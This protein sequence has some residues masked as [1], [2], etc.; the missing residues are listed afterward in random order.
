[1]I[2]H[3]N[4]MTGK[5][6]PRIVRGVVLSEAG[7]PVKDVVVSLTA[8]P[9]PLQDIAALTGAGGDFVLTAPAPGEYVVMASYP[10]GQQE[11]RTVAVAEDAIEVTLE[12]RPN[13]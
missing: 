3:G 10:S 9:V 1:M 12:V 8:G 11:S 2:E 4:D 13:Q 6:P 5:H 7:E